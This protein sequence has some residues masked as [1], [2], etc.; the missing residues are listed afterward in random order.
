MTETLAQ[1]LRDAYERN[2]V[3]DRAAATG[4]LLV[5]E[6]QD[7]D[8]IAAGRQAGQILKLPAAV[9]DLDPEETQRQAKA[10]EAKDILGQ[11][12]KRQEWVQQPGNALVAQDDLERLS[13]WERAGGFTQSFAA[14]IPSTVGIGLQ[15]LSREND[16]Q[17]IFWPVPDRVLGNPAMRLLNTQ[18]ETLR[19]QQDRFAEVVLRPVGEDLEAVCEGINV[20]PDQRTLANDI[21]GAFGQLAGQVALFF[22]GRGGNAA[23]LALFYGNGAEL[24]RDDS[25]VEFL[26]RMEEEGCSA[27]VDIDPRVIA[28][29]NRTNYARV[30]VVELEGL[31]DAL[32][33]LVHLGRLKT[34][35]QLEGKRRKLELVVE[36]AENSVRDSGTFTPQRVGR[37][38]PAQRRG[39]K[40][41][42]YGNLIVTPDTILKA[43]D[44]G[45]D[46][47]PAME[48][49]IATGL[50]DNG[51]DAICQA[52][53]VRENLAVFEDCSRTNR[54]RL[55]N[56]PG[57]WCS[58]V[59]R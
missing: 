48:Q 20:A 59:S 56:T 44:G 49:V 26:Q 18:L 42:E 46:L 9:T 15:R 13:W 52:Y 23:N 16:Q 50:A 28:R 30:P 34:A 11:A 2:Q 35:L 21:A 10:K 53:M 31:A 25:L 12:P 29:V 54:K 57:S 39:D 3:R 5:A 27:E 8:R 51:E 4:S 1:Q 41:D 17:R 55:T 33:K 32:K 45:K 40:L 7:P 22:L 36:A 19:T 58:L 43:L 6:E 47:G 38:T 37:G 14:A 24:R